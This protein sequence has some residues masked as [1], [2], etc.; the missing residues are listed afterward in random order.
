MNNETTHGN[1]YNLLKLTMEKSP[2]IF[3]ECDNE[4]T[5]MNS[6]LKNAIYNAQSKLKEIRSQLS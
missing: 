4:I 3:L 2:L 6:L 1:K 5:K